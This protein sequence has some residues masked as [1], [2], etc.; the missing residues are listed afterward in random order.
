MFQLLVA[1][2][3]H[4]PSSPLHF[5]PDNVNDLDGQGAAVTVTEI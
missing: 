4:L 1:P 5:V 3:V 2:G